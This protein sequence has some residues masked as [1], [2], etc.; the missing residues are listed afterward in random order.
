[1]NGIIPLYKPKGLTSHDCVQKIRRIL[2]IKKVGHTGT[3]DPEVE[4]VLP[5]C[6]GEATKV[7]PFLLS[8]PKEYEAEVALGS[9]TTTED[10][11]GDILEEKTMD[12]PPALTEVERVLQEF[13]GNV[14]QVPPMYSAVK[15]NGKKLYEYA[16]EGIEVERPVRT[17]TIH[18]AALIKEKTRIEEGKFQC[19]ILCSKGTYIRTLCVTIGAALG[20]PA[21]MSQLI[22]TKSDGI[23]LSETYT[24]DEVAE[25][26]Q[27]KNATDVFLPVVEGL[28]HL[29]TM[30]VDALEKRKVLQGQKL[31]FLVE[32]LQSTPF[33]IMH[34]DELLAIYDEHPT[35]KGIIK[36]VRV[37]NLYKNE[38]E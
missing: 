28:Q 18:E 1:M 12:E 13:Q 3:L 30:Q 33:K 37:F 34:E 19:R 5:I 8:L 2:H 26:Q 35:E 27:N 38:G 24:L 10:A 14:A 4:G 15:V 20:Y 31:S 29:P 22:R 16:R 25:A 9:T 11:E 23:H 32:N 6:V 36:P 21:H 17:I 7:I